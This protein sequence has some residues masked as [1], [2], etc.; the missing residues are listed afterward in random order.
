[1]SSTFFYFSPKTFEPF[2]NFP[3]FEMYLYPFKKSLLLK[4]LNVWNWTIYGEMLQ[5]NGTSFH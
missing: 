2:Y 4:L 3:I 1:M 5:H